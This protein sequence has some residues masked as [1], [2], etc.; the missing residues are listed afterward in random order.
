MHA[1]VSQR[2]LVV[3]AIL[4]IAA[5]FAPVMYLPAFWLPHQGVKFPYFCIL[6]ELALP[7]F[8]YILAKEKTLRPNIKSWV[9][10]LLFMYLVS[11]LISSFLGDDLRNSFWGNGWRMDGIFLYLHVFAFILYLTAL[12]KWKRDL[13]TR[14][15]LSIFT[16]TGVAT[17]VFGVLEYLEIITTLSAKYLPRASSW[18]GNPNIFASFLVIAFFMTLLLLLRSKSFYWK[19]VYAGSLLLMMLGLLASGT[20][21]SALGLIGGLIFMG[22]WYVFQEQSKEKRQKL[23]IWVILGIVATSGIIAVIYITSEE[24]SFLYRMTHLITDS[25]SERLLFWKMAIQGWIEKPFFGYGFNNYYIIGNEQFLPELYNYDG[26]WVDKPHNLFLE[27]LS[28]TGIFS[29]ILYIG[30]LLASV[31]TLWRSVKT[32]T[33]SRTSSSILFGLLAAHLIQQSFLFE[34]VTSLIAFAVFYAFILSLEE[35]KTKPTTNTPNKV[36]LLAPISS[37]ALVLAL[38]ILFHTPFLKDMKAI[39]AAYS[40]FGND[41]EEVIHQLETVGTHGFEFDPSLLASNAENM[42]SSSIEIDT[43][44]AEHHQRLFEISTSAYIKTTEVYPLRAI[45]LSEYLTLLSLSTGIETVNLE[46]DMDDIE[47]KAA[48]IAELAPNRIERYWQLAMLAEVDGE[49]EDAISIIQEGLVAVP[50]SATLNWFMG[51]YLM[52]TESNSAPDY[53]YIAIDNHFQAAKKDQLFWL[54]NHFVEKQ[55]F[56]KASIVIIRTLNIFPDEYQLYTNLAAAYMQLGEFEKAKESAKSILKFD[57]TYKDQV[58]AFINSI[59]NI[60]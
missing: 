38:L 47:Q 11:I 60:Q 18:F 17:A 37:I 8:A 32:K 49:Y 19:W 2:V 30:V 10:A 36:L 39:S 28:T 43:A 46:R 25:S 51:T 21:G 57:P 35:T 26:G 33:I 48:R 20:R 5:V 45:Y 52:N 7:F 24:N 29:L 23:L 1:K 53:M 4:T 27:I 50:N 42:A 9:L 40:A 55:E 12:L 59:P 13:F 14:I 41:W 34:T 3:F 16:L 6:I 56:E 31:K 54:I 58:D 44:S 15:I 22:L